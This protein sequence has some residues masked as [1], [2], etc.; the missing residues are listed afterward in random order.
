LNFFSRSLST[1]KG[2]MIPYIIK[3][4]SS[5][6]NTA[7]KDDDTNTSLDDDRKGNLV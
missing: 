5:R 2:E 1:L 4:Q 6:L 7:M 3:K